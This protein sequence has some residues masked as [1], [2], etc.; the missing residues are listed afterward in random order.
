MSQ[1]P[2]TRVT[3]QNMM[4]ET[5]FCVKDVLNPG[6]QCKKEWFEARYDE[7]LHLCIA[8]DLRGNSMGFIEFIPAS[9]AWRPVNAGGFMFIHCMYIYSRKNKNKGYGSQMI[10]HVEE[11]A[12]SKGMAG[13]CVVTSKGSWMTDRRIFEKNGYVLISKK[14]RFEL[15][16]KKWDPAAEDPSFTSWTDFRQ[17]YDGWHLLYADQCPWHEKSAQVL[18][19]TAEEYG[20]DLHVKKITSAEEVRKMPSGFGVFNLLYNGKLLE[21]HYISETRFRTI[22]KKEMATP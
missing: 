8:K 7:G 5:F 22:L 2:I 13:V 15:L 4:E 11:V 19:E 10:Q 1:I 3:P 14:D 17:S 21:D 6:F 16:A 18:K 20:I 9:K 12:R